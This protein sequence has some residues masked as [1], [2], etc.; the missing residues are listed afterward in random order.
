MAA[1]NELTDEQLVH[2]VLQAERDLVGARFSHSMQQLENT[3]ELRVL[4]RSIAR[5]LTES[6]RRESDQGL[7]KN[8]LLES[9]K[10]TFSA[11]DGAEADVGSEEKG[12]FLS[13]I[14]DKIGS[15]D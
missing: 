4:R 2:K 1:L 13:G 3:S 10:N 12:G 14:V 5:M 11:D 6:R 9:Y 7:P 8:A 15:A